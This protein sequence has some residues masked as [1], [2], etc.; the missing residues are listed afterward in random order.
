MTTNNNSLLEFQTSENG[1][2]EEIAVQQVPQK[3]KALIVDDVPVNRLIAKH[4]LKE[5]FDCREAENGE[6]AVHAFTEEK[7]DIILMDISMPVMNGVEA[8]RKIRELANGNKDIPII[9]VTTGG[10]LGNRH[11]LLREGFSEYIQKPVAQ[12][13]LYEKIS[14]F[15]SE[16]LF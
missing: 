2:E 13:E 14:C 15:L 1:E 9:A 6:E 16:A 3:L 7:P 11:E 12:Q 10:P 5:V 4:M 8:F